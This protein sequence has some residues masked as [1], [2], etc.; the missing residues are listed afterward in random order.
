VSNDDSKQAHENGGGARYEQKKKDKKSVAC[1][2]LSSFDG[3]GIAEWSKVAVVEKT[4]LG[5]VQPDGQTGTV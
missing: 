1:L 2:R 5:G 3:K 4:Y